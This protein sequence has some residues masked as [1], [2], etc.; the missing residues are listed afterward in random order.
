MTYFVIQIGILILVKC[1][2]F[3]IVSVVY[4]KVEN[5]IIHSIYFYTRGKPEEVHLDV[6]ITSIDFVTVYFEGR[7]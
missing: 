2:C 1:Q 4:S 6:K 7:C 5:C 3:L